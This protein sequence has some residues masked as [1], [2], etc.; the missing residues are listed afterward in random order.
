MN[1]IDF[2]QHLTLA[3][4]LFLIVYR[5]LHKKYTMMVVMGVAVIYE[6]ITYFFELGDYANLHHW[7]VDTLLDL[8]AAL[9][10]CIFCVLIL[11]DKK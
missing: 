8:G 7:K 6:A 5:F 9:I 2:W 10:A 4:V 1:Q 3:I 11:K